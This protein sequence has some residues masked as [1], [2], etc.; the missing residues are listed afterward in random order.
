MMDKKAKKRNRLAEEKSPYLLQHAENP[1]DWYPWGEEA[2]SKARTGNKPVFLSIGYSTCHWC[3]VMAHESFEDPEVAGLMNEVFVSVKVDREER[4]DIDGVYMTV[5]QALTGSGGWP[6]SIIMTPDKEPFFAATYIPKETRFGRIGMLELVPRIREMWLTR[7]SEVLESVGQITATL[8]R[9]VT[10]PGQV[11]G[12][13]ELQLAYDQLSIRYDADEGGFGTA[14]K[15]PTPHNLLFL[16]R[17]WRRTGNEDALSMVEKTLGAMRR[18]GIYDHIG[19]GFHR[20]STDANWLVPHY[21]KMLYDQALLAIAYIEAYQAIGKE[22]Y[23]RTAREIFSYVLRD[24]TSP[25]GG[26]YSAEDADSEGEEGK[27]Y[28]WTAGEIKQALPGTEADLAMKVFNT[29]KD[30]N[31]LDEVSGSKTGKNILHLT[32]TI[33]KIASSLDITEQ[34]LLEKLGQIREKLFDYRKKRVRPHR[35]DKILTDWNGLM[36]AALS[37]GARV[38]NEASYADTARQAAEFI[39]AKLILPDGK[40]LHRYRDGEAAVPANLDDY[41][42]LVYGLMELYETTFEVGYLKTALKLNGELLEHF[43]DNEAGGF[44]FTADDAES[45]IIRRKEIYDGAVPSGNSVAMLNLLRLGRI[46][47]DARLE[48]KAAKIGQA[49]AETVSES[50]SAYTMLMTAVDFAVGPSHEVV[51]AGES[52][53]SDTGEMLKA[54]NRCFVPNKVVILRP[55]EEEIPEIDGIVPFARYHSARHGK[56]TAYVCLDYNCQLPTTDTDTMLKLLSSE[57]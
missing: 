46:I 41:A 12:E 24:M 28:L 31:Y 32:E 47:A 25:E 23:A 57:Q 8:S 50:P 13:Q 7:K 17:Y 1:V 27:F 33:L 10:K 18:G 19:Y 40:L 49:F 2:F 35:D 22:E 42:F 56:A 29:N 55:A 54:L 39:S 26:F 45:L 34:E 5:C 11:P 36:I 4:P 51:I 14:P 9:T 21:E 16:L 44:F 52:F 3:H 6:L 48:D 43:W 20:Y 30:G 15:F 53:G 37:K 38:L